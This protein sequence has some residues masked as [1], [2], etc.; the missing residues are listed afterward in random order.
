MI[1]TL[2]GVVNI[3]ILSLRNAAQ[4]AELLTTWNIAVVMGV[5]CYSEFTAE[6][7]SG[8]S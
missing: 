6:M 3:P 5:L 1:L 8:G 7:V 4:I 2:D